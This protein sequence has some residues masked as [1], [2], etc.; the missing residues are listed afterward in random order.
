MEFIWNLDRRNSICNVE[1]ETQQLISQ[2]LLRLG[3]VF[4]E[5]KIECLCLYECD[6]V[7]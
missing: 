2:H 3:T 6:F 7:L 1:T 5:H 4:M